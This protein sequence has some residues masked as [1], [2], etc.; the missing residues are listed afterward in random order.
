M[1]L[2]SKAGSGG[3]VFR[4]S[5]WRPGK[6]QRREDFNDWVWNRLLDRKKVDGKSRKFR[7]HHEI[8]TDGVAASLLLS[9]EA[10]L[11]QADASVPRC[12]EVAEQGGQIAR[13]SGWTRPWKEKRGH[14]GGRDGSVSV[15]HHEAEKL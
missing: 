4:S 11:R 7:F 10:S 3:A 6:R 13:T 15:I 2:P 5:P 14:H 1:E 12:N 8:T 9:R